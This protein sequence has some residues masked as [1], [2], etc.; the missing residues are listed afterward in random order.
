MINYIEKGSGLHG[1]IT[2]NSH[3]LK[4]VDGT[5]VSSDDVAVQAIIDSYDPLPDARTEAKA[6]LVAQVNEATAELEAAYPEVIK[7]T[8]ER[9][10]AEARAYIADP[11]AVTPTLTK[12]ATARGLDLSTLAAR[13]IYKADAYRDVVDGLNVA[14]Q[15]KEDQIDAETDWQVISTINL[16]G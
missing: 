11:N 16:G 2:K 3:Y 14:M 13:V 4:Q 8:F 5:W 7:R 6:R 10:E 12:I 15:V 9:Q 1:A